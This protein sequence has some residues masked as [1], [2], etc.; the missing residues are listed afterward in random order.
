MGDQQFVE[1]FTGVS[2]PE[3]VIKIEN[4]VPRDSKW[5]SR[6]QDSIR[7]TEDRISRA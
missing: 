4:R 7:K 5:A 3:G 1:K 6:E 2:K